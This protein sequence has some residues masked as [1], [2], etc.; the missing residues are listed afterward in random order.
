MEIHSYEVL[1]STNR[2]AAAAARDGAPAFYTV[3]AKSQTAGRGRLDRRFCSPVGGTYFS[4]VLRPAIPRNRY[5]ALT[6]FAALAVRRALAELLGVQADIK[7]VNDLYVGSKKICGILAESGTDKAGEPFVILGIGINT[8]KDPLP[9]EIA[10]IAAS[11]PFDDPRALIARILAH[12]K[13]A[14]TAI[15]TESWLSEYR[16]HCLWRGEYVCVRTGDA[17]RTALMLEV[18]ADGA[19]LVEWEDGKRESLYGGEIS[20]RSA[21]KGEI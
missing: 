7:W 9:P 19:L 16:A 15:C 2:T 18:E 11:V 17:A 5:T 6:P 13:G 14:E 10:E 20:L 1:P 4:T 3:W 21:Q 12:L 8:G